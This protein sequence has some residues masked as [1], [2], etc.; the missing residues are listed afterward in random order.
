MHKFVKITSVFIAFFLLS[1]C[2]I[3]KGNNLTKIDPSQTKIALSKKKKIYVR[4]DFDFIP[5]AYSNMTYDDRSRLFER[6]LEESNCCELVKKKA[7]ADIIFEGKAYDQRNP[8]RFVGFF[9]TVATVYVIPSWHVAKIFVTA[10]VKDGKQTRHFEASDSMTTA[11]W[12]PFIIATPFAYDFDKTQ[13]EILE[14]SF[15]S[16]LLQIKNDFIF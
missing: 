3:F 16:I 13:K 15:R 12:L 8:A 14:N 5:I 7:E 1:G 6:I 10:D 4:W 9:I 11:I 2:V